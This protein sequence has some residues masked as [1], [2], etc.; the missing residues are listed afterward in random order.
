MKI[1]VDINHPAHVH[2]FKNFI[3]EMQKKGHEILI[4]AS[5]KDISYTLLDNYGFSYVKIGNYGKSI[6]EKLVNIPV[7]DLKM[8]QAVRK[9]RPDLFLGF[10]SIRA[11]HVSKV[12]GK[13]YIALDDTEHAKWE[14]MLYVPF[15]DAIL[16]PA[17]F[18]KDFGKKHIRYKGYTELQYLHPNRFTPNPAVLDKIGLAPGDPYIILRFIS[19]DANHDIGQCGIQDRIGI[20]KVLEKYG[21]VLITSEG[22]LPD[23]LLSNKIQ[24]APEKLHDLLYYASLYIGEGATVA[25]EAAIL[26]TPSIYVSSLAGS[27][28]NFTELEETY[29]LLYRLSDHDV[30][31]RKASEILSDPAC[32]EIW[33]I[34]RNHLL[35]DKI[36][37]TAFIVWFIENYPKSVAEKNEHPEIRNRNASEPGDGS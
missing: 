13:P 5:E 28:G 25:T 34:K 26:G 19:W 8:Y 18:K 24:V 17:C 6:L 4:T 12:M 14:H 20:V 32:K 23:E 11:A 16:T 9:F 21:R 27:M 33:K 15:T 10:G 22:I 37:V 2:Y 29:D 7:L 3:W 30:V 35:K 31:L 1:V 36:D